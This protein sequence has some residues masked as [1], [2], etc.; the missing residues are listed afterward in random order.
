LAITSKGVMVGEPLRGFSGIMTG[1]PDY[2]GGLT[3]NADAEN[4]NI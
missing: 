1:I 4:S 2:R 3:Q